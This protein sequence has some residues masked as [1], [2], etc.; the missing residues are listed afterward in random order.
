MLAIALI[1][2]IT[3]AVTIGPASI[4]PADVWQS[5]LSRLGIGSVS[6]PELL[7]SVVW[8]LRLPRVLTAACVGAGLALSG[9]VMQGITRNAL[10]DPYLLG[11]SSGAALGAVS[12]LLLGLAVLLPV[13]AFAGAMLA[14]VLTLSLATALGKLTPTRTVLAGLAVSS[15]A[16]AVT[17][18]V[19][20]WT[21][22]GDSYRQILGWLMGS[23]G[24]ATWQSVAISA[25]ALL[26]VGLPISASGRIIDGFAFGDTSAASLGINV[27]A[28]R[29]LMLAGTAL[30]TGAMVAVSGSIGFVGLVLPHVV[31]LLGGTRHRML[32]PMSA[33]GG[34]V[35]LVWA[36]T[37]ARTVFDPQ[38]IPVG[39]IT[40]LIGAPVFAILLWQ[41]RGAA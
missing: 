35:F 2:S 9:A 11:L 14:L 1:V 34:A 24:G 20:F 12:V 7:D 17:S 8:E 29:W 15:L 16:S 27:T 26:V 19:I 13:A 40:A 39:I 33:L 6:L 3:L 18:F 28:V 22:Q 37:I 31:R 5:V 25:I 36:D 41:K 10:A 21:A 23:I 32:L 38:E 30:L 4:S